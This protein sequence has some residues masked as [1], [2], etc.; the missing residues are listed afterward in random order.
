[1]HHCMCLTLSSDKTFKSLQLNRKSDVSVFNTAPACKH[2]PTSSQFILRNHQN[3][4]DWNDTCR[5]IWSQDFKG[6]CM[7]VVE[8]SVVAHVTPGFC[9]YKLRKGT[10]GC[11]SPCQTHA[12]L[13]LIFWMYL[14]RLQIIK[15]KSE[16]L[17]DWQSVSQYVLVYSPLW[18]LRPDVIFL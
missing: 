12:T 13:T 17:C 4:G 7:H 1:M 8:I 14:Y 9:H 10:T 16:L 6:K 2:I 11:P 3:T 18:D 15:S 5:L